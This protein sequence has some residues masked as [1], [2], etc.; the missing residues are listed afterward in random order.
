MGAFVIEALHINRVIT[1]DVHNAEDI[2]RQI[3]FDQTLIHNIVNAVADR[4]PA[5]VI[6]T[7]KSG[8]HTAAL[9]SKGS[10]VA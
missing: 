10:K 6:V 2:A 8:E 3:A 9:L 1:A 7:G 5:A 4:V